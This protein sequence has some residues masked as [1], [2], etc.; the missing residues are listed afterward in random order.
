M[1]ISTSTASKY[2]WDIIQNTNKDIVESMSKEDIKKLELLKWLT[3]AQIKEILY[4]NTIA[5][6]TNN[7]DI[8]TDNIGH[9]TF[10]IIGDTHLWSKHCNYEWLHKYYDEI[11][12]RWIKVVVHAGDM[13]DGFGVYKWQTFELAKHS[14]EEQIQDVVDNYPKRK[15]IDTYRIGWNHD[16]ARLKIAGYDISK[17][18]DNLRED[19]HN[20]WRYNARIKING[21]YI[22]LHHWWWGN[23]YSWSYK[24]QKYMENINPKDQPNVYVL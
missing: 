14:M 17:S 23:S 22:E 10:G 13:V 12:K 18:I 5:T 3:P 24:P 7:V 21:V 20:L 6:K 9:A 4:Q 1:G 8:I 2:A 19:L 11:K 15:W 16:E